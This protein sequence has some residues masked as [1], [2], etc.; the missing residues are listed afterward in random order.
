MLIVGKPPSVP[1]N[2]IPEFIAYAK[3]NPGKI[4]MA[5]P[6]VGTCELFKMIAGVNV[7]HVPYRGSALMLTDLIG[8]QVQV[9]LDN[10]QSALPHVTAG[11]LR[12][13]AVTTAMR[14]EELAD[15]PTVNDF[16]PGYEASTWNGVCAPK[17]TAAEIVDILN[18]EINAGLADPKKG[19]ARRGGCVGA[20]G[21]A[22][23]LRQAHRCRNR[24]V[25]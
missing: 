1:A 23:R 12:A 4:N 19:T 6:G 8:G 22:R 3:A 9:A 7:V 18:N 5:S 17:N 11:T 20:F 15:V 2:T 25:G 14:S 24:E 16:L 21:F 10:P 13:L